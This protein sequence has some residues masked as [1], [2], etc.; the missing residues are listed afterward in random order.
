MGVGQSK[1]ADEKSV[2]FG[3]GQRRRHSTR[4]L[5]AAGCLE[6]QRDRVI[7]MKMLAPSAARKVAQERLVYL[8]TAQEHG[9]EL[10]GVLDHFDVLEEHAAA[11]A[12]R[13][14]TMAPEGHP[15]HG[16]ASFPPEPDRKPR[17]PSAEE[18]DFKPSADEDTK[19][20]AAAANPTCA[21]HDDELECTCV[22]CLDGPKS[23]ILFP[24]GHQCLCEKCA[25]L[26]NICPVCRKKVANKCKVY[27]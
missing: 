20:S 8:R 12:L 6:R 15:P 9:L 22:V 13:G 26:I 7:L 5:F 21:E 14:M 18:N 2:P 24:C 25:E 19:K 16:C 1:P 27:L 3:H 10:G 23:H 11:A 4:S 17:L